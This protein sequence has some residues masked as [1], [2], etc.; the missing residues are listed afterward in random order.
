MN[1]THLKRADWTTFYY[2]NVEPSKLNKQLRLVEPII[3]HGVNNGGSN[4][5]GVAGDGGVVWPPQGGKVRGGG[6]CF[7]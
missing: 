6:E 1:K 4:M 7:K 3:D 5:Q 2:A